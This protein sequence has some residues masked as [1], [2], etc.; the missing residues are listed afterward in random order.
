MKIGIITYHK[1]HNYGALLQAI[2]L[3][4]KLIQMGHEV[5]FIDY[6]PLYHKQLYDFFSFKEM[7]NYGIKDAIKYGG[8]IIL[9]YKKRKKRIASFMRFIEELSS[10]IVLTIPQT[11]S[12]ISL[13]M[14]V[15]RYGEN[16]LNYPIILILYIL[17]ITY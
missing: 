7:F 15:T 14:G 10:P 4:I 13:F 12:L 1:S 8:K 5:Y 16:S 2:A 9:S 11:I 3:R 17:L 6:W